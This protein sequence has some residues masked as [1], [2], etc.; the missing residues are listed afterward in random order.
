MGLWSRSSCH[1]LRRNCNIT[2][3]HELA[4]QSLYSKGWLLWEDRDFKGSVDA[5]QT[6]V[7]RFPKHEL[8]PNSYLLINHVYL[9][10]ALFEFQNPDLLALAEINTQ[11]F[12]RA[13]P[14][15]ERI[16]DAEDSVRCVREVYA[17]GLY[18][19]GIFYEKTDKPR[20]A[21]LYYRN[22]ISRFPDTGFARAA[23]ERLDCLLT[24]PEN[25]T[26]SEASVC[27]EPPAEG[28]QKNPLLQPE[29]EDHFEDFQFDDE[30]KE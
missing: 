15:E 11:R 19:I 9:E 14:K 28:S 6:V 25:F 4:V 12:I 21:I 7:R 22:T 29:E 5:F 16:A 17:K 26:S 24:V 2:P 8:T 13:F 30:T 23:R 18:D 3:S 20:A 1:H 27:L 10:Q